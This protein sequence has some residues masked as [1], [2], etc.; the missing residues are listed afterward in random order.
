MV[1]EKVK[2]TDNTDVEYYAQTGSKI[3]LVA[4]LYIVFGATMYQWLGEMSIVD[5]YYFVVVTLATVGY[6]DI[7]PH[8]AAGKV[9]TIFYIIFGLAIFSALITNIVKRARERREKKLANKD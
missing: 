1:E 9:F 7:T 6:G 4:G 2:E 3:F 5:S 8:T